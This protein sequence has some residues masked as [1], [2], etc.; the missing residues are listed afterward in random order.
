MVLIVLFIMIGGMIGGIVIGEA[1]PRM[2]PVYRWLRI[3]GWAVWLSALWSCNNDTTANGDDIPNWFYTGAF[4][5]TLIFYCTF[6][7]P[8]LPPAGFEPAPAPVPQQ[9]RPCRLPPRGPGGRFVK[10]STR[11]CEEQTLPE[12]RMEAPDQASTADSWRQLIMPRSTRILL[13]I[14]ACLLF[15]GGSVGIVANCCKPFDLGAILIGVLLC[16]VAFMLVHAVI[17]CGR[18]LRNTAMT[19]AS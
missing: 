7:I 13:V 8:V 19:A 4:G 5:L 6:K 11:I 12:G 17:S 15:S 14:L 10:A 16:G 2:V 9:K 1:K 3:A 18:R